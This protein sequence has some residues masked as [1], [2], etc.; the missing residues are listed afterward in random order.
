MFLKVFD[1]FHCHYIFPLIFR[2]YCVMLA[3]MSQAMAENIVDRGSMGRRQSVRLQDIAREANLSVSAVSK[4][5]RG[6]PHVS[7]ETRRRVLSI[8]KRLNYKAHL[9][10]RLGEVASGA[11]TAESRRSA[12]LVLFDRDPTS[13]SASRWLTLLTHEAEDQGLRLELCSL[14]RAN[15]V[16]DAASLKDRL[17]PLGAVL[18]LGCVSLDVI[19]AVRALDVPCVVLGDIESGLPQHQL[20]CHLIASDKLAMAGLATQTLIEAGH[21]RIGFFCASFPRGGWS[22]MWLTG[23]RLAMMRAGLDL[24]PRIHPVFEDVDRDEVGVAAAEYMLSLSDPPTAYVIPAVR[25]AARFIETMRKHGVHLD[26]SRVIMG[27]QSRGP[28]SDRSIYGLDDYPLI[29]EDASAMTRTAVDLVSRLVDGATPPTATILVP[30]VV[31]NLPG[32]P[33]AHAQN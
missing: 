22:D 25:G 12:G 30:Y 18:V 11:V 1:I 5:L 27:G 4:A 23:Y 13:E 6:Y 9:R 26:P 16:R 14:T 10:E 32:H 31:W 20:P 15:A 7:E 29:S 19:E 8:S 33:K 2:K 28:F 17:A 24:D 3:G 21:R